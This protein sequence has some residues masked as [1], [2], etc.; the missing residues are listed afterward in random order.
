MTDVVLH[1]GMGKTGTSS[2]QEWCGRNRPV[3]AEHGVLYPRTPG[4]FR[5]VRLG[6]MT[7]PLAD[8]HKM[9]AWV[10]M[11]RNDPEAFQAEVRA[12]A[13]AEIRSAGLPRVLFSNEGFYGSSE[14]AVAGVRDFLSSFASTV[15]VVVYLRRQDD[16]LLSRYQQRIKV[17]ATERL[18]SR[19]DVDLTDLYDYA[20]RLSLWQRVVE[21]TELVVRP[22]EREQFV[23]GS[24]NQDF[25]AAAGISVPA[26]ALASLPRTNESLDADAVEFLRIF[27]LFRVEEKG[28]TD[29]QIDNRDLVA[30]LSARGATGPTLG[31][32]DDLLDPF[33]ARWA[34][35]NATV[36]RTWLG[37]PDGVLFT[38][39]KRSSNVTTE[40]R[41]PLDR[42]P[43]LLEV[44]EVSAA[45]RS[46][47]RRVAEREAASA[48]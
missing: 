33:L 21:P 13:L 46:G 15:R 3:L 7:T 45:D 40:Q 10:R 39:A 20:A 2:L 16:H 41:L 31:L 22:F 5:H 4:R 28:A 44:A 18:A 32:A 42:L 27:N 9:P 1:I 47:V 12:E 29:G 38:S 36:A 43:D 6:L 14:E 25:L 35:A 11:N 30:R 19:L 34:D 37:R 8:L 17:G 48:Q 26:D 23:G 24:L